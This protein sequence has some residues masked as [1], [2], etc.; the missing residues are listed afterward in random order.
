FAEITE[1]LSI[2]L[3]P[4]IV[5]SFV[6]FLSK[7]QV[8]QINSRLSLYW[9]LRAVTRNTSSPRVQRVTFPEQV[10]QSRCASSGFVN[11][12]RFLKR[13]VVSV[14]APTGHTSITLP[15][16]SLSITFSI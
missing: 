7:R 16:K 12:T 1:F 8:L 3:G 4:S 13:Q 5:Q 11:Q 15:E 6:S 14:S 9:F 10:G 2:W